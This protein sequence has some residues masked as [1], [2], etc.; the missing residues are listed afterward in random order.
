MNLS[1]NISLLKDIQTN[2]SSAN[3]SILS[4]LPQLTNINS[5]LSTV[6]TNLT[7]I[8]SVLD[9]T[10]TLQ[11]SELQEMNTHLNSSDSYLSVVVSNGAQL[12]VKQDT[13]HTKLDTINT[14]LDTIHDKLIEIGVTLSRDAN[15]IFFQDRLTYDGNDY[16]GYVDYSSSPILGA[17]RNTLNKPIYVTEFNFAYEEA[18]EPDISGDTYHSPRF[19][20]YIGKVDNNDNFQAP[21]LTIQDNRDQPN[22]MTKYDSYNPISF[23]WTYDFTSNPIELGVSGRFGHYIEGDMTS[24]YYDS[25]CVGNIKGYYYE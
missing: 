7:T 18:S 23:C 12:L 14:E 17:Y 22:N 9:N 21:Y 10:Y 25:W 4:H 24:T 1:K 2:T 8:D 20:T 3:V 11:L 6:N 13:I 16:L 19:T 15:K 5:N